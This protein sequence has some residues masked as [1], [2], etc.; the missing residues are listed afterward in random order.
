MH[1]GMPQRR[2]LTEDDVIM[3]DIADIITIMIDDVI[4]PDVIMSA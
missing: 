3:S 4:I 2:T 1:R